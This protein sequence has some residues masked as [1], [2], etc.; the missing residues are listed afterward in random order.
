MRSMRRRFINAAAAFVAVSVGFSAG[1]ASAQPGGAGW[2]SRAVKLV[3][4]FPPG[5]APDTL[6]R[7]LAEQ[8]AADWGQPV[9]V[10]NAPG[11]AGNIGT[12]RVAKSS[13]DGYTLLLAGD[14]A[15]VVNISLYKSLPYDPVRDLAPIS[16]ITI[17]PNVLVVNPAVPANNMAELVALAR[18]QPGKLNAASAGFGTSQHIGLEQ[19]KSSAGVEIVHV[20]YRDPYLNDLLGNHVNMAYF[21][22]V[23]ALPQIRAGK[24]RALALGYPSRLD[25]AEGIPTTA[26]AGFPG[27][28]AFAWFGMYAPAGTP[29]AVIRKAHAGAV[30]A[31]ARPTVRER[32]GGL[33]MQ[34]VGSSPEELAAHIKAE[35]PRMAKIIKDSGARVE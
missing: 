35:I 26:E 9:V 15:I 17:T 3:V 4:P 19:L 24:L 27:V 32:L 34:L 1:H 7:V 20:P 6:G 21:N 23:Q 16:Q 12:D 2:P 11:A 29:D 13:P 14:A 30:A 18:A 22:V 33:G 28:T 25:I 10:E 8:F 5:T 31:L